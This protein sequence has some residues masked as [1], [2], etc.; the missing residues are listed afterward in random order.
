MKAFAMILTVCLLVSFLAGCAGV[1]AAPVATEPPAAEAPAT[2]A[3]AAEAPATEAPLSAQDAWFQA[4]GLGQFAPATQDWA[5]IEAAAKAEG[6]VL[7]YANSSRIEKAAALWQEKYPDITVE[8]YD[9]GGDEAV[10]KV[11]EEQ[12]AG[13]YVGDVYFAGGGPDVFG[14]LYPKGYLVPFV[15]DDLLSALPEEARNP[16]PVSRYGVRTLGYNTELN[17]DGCPIT[18]WWQLTEPALKGK[19]YIE[20]P[21]TDASTM[22]IL[23]TI[24]SH[25]DELAAAYKELYGSDPVLDADTPD[26]G[27]LWVKK[28]AQNSPVPEPGGDEVVQAFATPGMTEAGVGFTSYS[29]Y[30]DTLTGELVFDA[31]RGVKPVMGV[32]TQA[33]LAIMNQAPHPNAAKLFIN[34]ILNEG[35]EPWNVIGDYSART[36]V[37]APEGAIPRE[38][39]SVWSQDDDFVYKNITKMRDFWTINF[40]Q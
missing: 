7:V 30:R 21:L 23:T 25:A 33:Y 5:A 14:E 17:P 22:G 11:R 39:L 29:K 1:P 34:F 32:Q 40:L 13:A 4:A 36:D 24:A 35:F 6:K 37:A 3:P 19:V 16:F 28:F 8:G 15:P 20:D 31:C 10:V 2:E 18:N 27:W 9:L 38:E 12:K 26:A